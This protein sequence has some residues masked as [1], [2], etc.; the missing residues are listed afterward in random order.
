MGKTSNPL[1]HVSNNGKDVESVNNVI[2]LLVKKLGLD[3][4]FEFLENILSILLEQ[5]SSYAMFVVV[6][7]YFDELIEKA[8]QV[9]EKVRPLISSF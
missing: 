7:E 2:E 5:V 9:I 8:F 4:I 6:K 3:P 1:Y